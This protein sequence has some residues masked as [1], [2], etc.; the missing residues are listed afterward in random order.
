MALRIPKP[1]AP[2]LFKDGYK[3]LQGVDEAVL[4]NIAACRD[5][6]EI[7]RTSFG[8]NGRNKMVVNYLE[9]LFVT[10]DA[11]TIIRELEV[12]H[13]AAKMLVMASQQ[14]ESEMGD[15]TNLVIVI[16]GELLKQAE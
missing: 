1:S 11:A 16:A 4:R 6:T 3:L 10:S 2:Q 15:A 13:P 5:L 14:Q 9:K 8:P 7:T 12:V